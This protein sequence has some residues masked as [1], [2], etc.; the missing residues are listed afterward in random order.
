VTYKHA[1]SGVITAMCLESDHQD[2]K[3]YSSEHPVSAWLLIMQKELNEAMD[4]WVTGRG[5][6]AALSEIL[7]VM[8]VG[9]RC[10]QQHGIVTRR[11]EETTDAATD[12]DAGRALDERVARL[13]AAERHRDSWKQHTHLRTKQLA[14]V[15]DDL[16]KCK[17]R[18][19]AA[20]AR[21]AILTD[22]LNLSDRDAANAQ[23]MARAA[24]ARV[25]AL[26]AAAR[27][28]LPVCYD[29]ETDGM[30]VATVCR[31]CMSF[32]P[33]DHSEGCPVGALAALG[34][35]Q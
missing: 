5:D 19:D 21:V 27:A 18:V 26:E 14:I 30:I 28:V 17:E 20:E 22:E 23:E 31:A 8:T 11:I 1:P 16:V 13:R 2:A 7:Q 6:S 25:A 35:E 32:E 12:L 10:L 4:A 34:G 3:G 29:E 15:R 33:T 24:E 9:M